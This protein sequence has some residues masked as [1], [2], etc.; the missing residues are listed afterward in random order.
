MPLDRKHGGA[1]DRRRERLRYTIPGG[2]LDVQATTEPPDALI[3]DRVDVKVVRRIRA[4]QPAAGNQRDVVAMR[5]HCLEVSL[6][7]RVVCRAEVTPQRAA[8]CDVQFLEAAA[9]AEYRAA[10]LEHRLDQPECHRVAAG[11]ERPITISVAVALGGDVRRAARQQQ[12]VEPRRDFARVHQLGKRRDQQRGRVGVAHRRGG[13]ACHHRLRG[14]A[15]RDPVAGDDADDRACSGSGA[16]HRL[17]R[18]SSAARLEMRRCV[19]AT[20][21][22]GRGSSGRPRRGS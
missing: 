13:V 19:A 7:G 17:S 1:A 21:R 11:V 2:R 14:L 5:E 18:R 22:T 8:E 6:V 15:S 4:R 12:R 3:V 16:R 10:A 20:C 9:D